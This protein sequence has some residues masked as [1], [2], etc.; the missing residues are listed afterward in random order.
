M[1]TT[2]F[3][4]TTSAFTGY[5]SALD[6]AI[7]PKDRITEDAFRDQSNPRKFKA[8]TVTL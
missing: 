3:D 7:D 2:D 5:S 6:K 8:R 4:E 1:N